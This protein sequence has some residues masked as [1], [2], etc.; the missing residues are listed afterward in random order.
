MKKIIN[1]L[2]VLAAL[3]L[4]GC[5]SGAKHDAAVDSDSLFDPNSPATSSTAQSSVAAEVAEV[6]ESEPEKAEKSQDEKTENIK[7]RGRDGINIM[8]RGGSWKVTDINDQTII[9]K[10]ICD[11]WDA[12]LEN[13]DLVDFHGRIEYYRPD[14]SQPFAYGKYVSYHC[15]EYF[16]DLENSEDPKLT[17][18]NG[19]REKVGALSVDGF[20]YPYNVIADTRDPGNV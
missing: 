13:S 7:G 15:T 2:L 17:Y 10:L 12:N 16:I 18:P 4:V 11:E 3:T 8:A 14:E 5:G 20:I 1:Y 9:I 6:S 19:E